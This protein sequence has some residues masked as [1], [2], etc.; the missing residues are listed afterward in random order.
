M[1]R[2]LLFVFLFTIFGLLFINY[3][4]EAKTF[5][6][7]YNDY[8]SMNYNQKIYALHTTQEQGNNF[9]YDTLDENGKEIYDAFL[10]AIRAGYPFQVVI[11]D[12]PEAELQALFDVA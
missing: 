2:K 4:V 5:G 10:P 1:K 8:A 9:Y 11:E 12:R 6:D 3:K 7:F